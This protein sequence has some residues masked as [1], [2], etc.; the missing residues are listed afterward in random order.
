MPAVPQNII[1]DI[2]E[3]MLNHIYQ[4]SHELRGARNSARYAVRF[5][6]SGSFFER[7]SEDRRTDERELQGIDEEIDSL[8]ETAISFQTSLNTQIA[9]RR[10]QRNSLIP[11]NQI[12]LE[13]ISN[14]LW[15]SIVDPWPRR[16]S[17][18]FIRRQQTISSVCASWRTLVVDS[19]RFWSIVEFSCR[20][21]AISHFLKKSQS[22]R[23]EI[24]SFAEE[25]KYNCGPREPFTEAACLSLIAPHAH[26]IR[27]L[28][29]SL[30]SMDGLLAVLE[31]PAPMLE[32][33]KLSCSYCDFER[34]LNLFCG[35]AS[36]LRD[37]TLESIPVRWDSDVLVGLRSL[38][39]EE[40]FEYLPT[41][42]QVRR[43]LE[44]NP[45]LEKL[46]IDSWGRTVTE[47]FGNDAVQSAG[48]GEPIRVV[49]GNMQELT[50]FNLPFELVQ[51]V[52]GH[53]EIPAIKYLK[54]EYWFR[55]QPAPKLLGSGIK[56]LVSHLLQ[57]YK[58]PR[59]AEL[60]FGESSMDLVIYITG[61]ESPTIGIKLNQTVLISGLDWLPENLF[62]AEGLSSVCAG[63]A[64]Q[65]SL[66]FNDMFDMG[67][68]TFIP[69]LDR[70]NAVKVKNLTVEESCHH[71]EELIMYLGEVK[72]DSHWPLPYVTS[73]TVGGF[74]ELADHLLIALQRRMPSAPTGE[75][76]V[77]PQPA[78]LEVLNIENL[79][80]VDEDVEKSLAECVTGRGTFIPARR[81]V[82]QR[83]SY[84]DELDEDDV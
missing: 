73:M 42:E 62:H 53:V 10:K 18:S 9:Q 71:G 51:A 29:L 6:N 7:S 20:P 30:R 25:S 83:G 48:Q 84:L 45:G 78:M 40:T 70:L 15:L 39:I 68:G 32:E 36:Q 49:M 34:P 74:A 13:I 44:A 67:G 21:A 55:G 38:T 14:I 61:Y 3:L 23:L 63:E 75:P 22:S 65:V 35:Q 33:L 19:P 66:K 8:E 76:P 12:P 4:K 2:T 57:R 69:I 80:E 58:A 52:L 46:E 54:L 26:R 17:Y 43:L 24:K 50:L 59:R 56:H 72:E 41:T 47:R 81:R 64:F 5:S 82:H 11:F 16:V 60:T 1:S 37:V 77:T 28:I 27:S 79:F 31:E